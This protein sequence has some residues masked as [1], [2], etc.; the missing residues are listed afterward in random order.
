MEKKV[1]DEVDDDGLRRWLLRLFGE[2][3]RS[4][5]R[6]T[7]GF[8]EGAI[9]IRWT[10]GPS[11]QLGN[12]EFVP[13]FL[14]HFYCLCG[15]SL[16]G[17][18]EESRLFNMAIGKQFGHH[19]VSKVAI[20]C[21]FE[22]LRRRCRPIFGILILNLRLLLFYPDCCL[23]QPG[24]RIGPGSCTLYMLQLLLLLYH[25]KCISRDVMQNELP[26]CR[27]W[28]QVWVS[29]VGLTLKIGVARWG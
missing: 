29:F 26:I 21:C 13:L 14:L 12:G 23:T 10:G 4:S 15:S 19:R 5:E 20:L 16:R 7:E 8:E 24:S 18:D 9:A 3:L 11:F 25:H 17:S 27:S 1:R 22:S 6:S 28:A 2:S